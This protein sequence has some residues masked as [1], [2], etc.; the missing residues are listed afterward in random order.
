[1]QGKQRKR[2]CN[3]HLHRKTGWEARETATRDRDGA[4]IRI[5][6]RAY[7]QDAIKSEDDRE[8]RLPVN[9]GGM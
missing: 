5:L 4:L 8:V 6:E 2:H 7:C 3:A 9:A 1:M